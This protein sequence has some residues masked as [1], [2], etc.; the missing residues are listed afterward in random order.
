VVI[1]FEI[2]VVVGFEIVVVVGFEI[3]VVVGFEIVVAVGFEIFGSY[4]IYSSP[5]NVG[6]FADFTNLLNPSD[7]KLDMQLPIIICDIVNYNI[8]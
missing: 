1:G 6:A 2:V 5:F 3:V 8:Y 4:T 7:I